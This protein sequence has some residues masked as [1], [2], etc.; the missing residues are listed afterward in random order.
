[1]CHTREESSWARK[2]CTWG[3]PWKADSWRQSVTAVPAAGSTRPSLKGESKQCLFT[4]I[5]RALLNWRIRDYVQVLSTLSAELGL[6]MRIPL[7]LPFSFA[8]RIQN[9][10]YRFVIWNYLW[11]LDMNCWTV[12]R[13]ANLVGSIYLTSC[14]TT[15]IKTFKSIPEGLTAPAIEQNT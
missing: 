1:M 3:D 11:F 15:T 12:K 8:V 6:A 14:S 13:L 7:S 9:L 2:R 4:S 5:L 10:S